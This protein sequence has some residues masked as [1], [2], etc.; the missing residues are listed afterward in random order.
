MLSYSA[1]R[2]IPPHGYSRWTSHFLNL[3]RL[4]GAMSAMYS[5]VL[6][7]K[8]SIQRWCNPGCGVAKSGHYSEWY[9]WVSSNWDLAVRSRNYSWL[10]LFN[11][12]SS[13]P[14]G[15]VVSKWNTAISKHTNRSSTST[16]SY[17]GSTGS[18]PTSTSPRKPLSP[19]KLLNSLHKEPT[20]QQEV[21]TRKRGKQHTLQ[22]SQ[23][24]IYVLGKVSFIISRLTW[25]FKFFE[26]QN[27]DCFLPERCVSSS[28][29]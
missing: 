17:N 26:N 18:P 20:L 19:S 12:R 24:I 1:C 10:G 11:I 25:F 9:E 16:S 7:A 5:Q 4:F 28:S 8:K 13:E 2:T 23:K 22:W 27:S 6:R 15:S 21:T 29:Q 3:R 14:N